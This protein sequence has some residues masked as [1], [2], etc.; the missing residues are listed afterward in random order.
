MR[1]VAVIFPGVLRAPSF[2]TA[3]RR[4]APGHVDAVEYRRVVRPGLSWAIGATALVVALSM[5]RAQY[6]PSVRDVTVRPTPAG[7]LA[8]LCPPGTLPD[9]AVCIPAP[10]PLVAAS[11]SAG[12]RGQGP[13]GIPRRTERPEDYTRYRL[14]LASPASVGR[15]QV[16]AAF[17]RDGGATLP[18]IAL[19]GPPGTPVLARSLEG[20][21]GAATVV[22]AGRAIGTTIVTYHVVERANVRQEF[23]V[24][25]G[26]LGTNE[27]PAP[28]LALE[29]GA[30]LGK[31]SRAPLYLDVR[32]VR[33]AID[34]FA[35]SLDA[36]LS[37]DSSVSVD[38]RNVYPIAD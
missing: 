6:R 32:L 30:T 27:V 16:D 23:L 20:Q 26:N 21:Q 19:R 18:G 25:L 31:T 15:A 22:A 33:P 13:S 3:R 11:A 37:D 10:P 2:S 4:D 12:A 14:P 35:L 34:V 5:A 38:A 8:S 36:L 9:E 17:A 29:S 24:V 1:K 28:R 7:G